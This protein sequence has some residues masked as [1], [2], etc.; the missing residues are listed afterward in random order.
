MDWKMPKFQKSDRVR[1]QKPAS[2]QHDRI[3]KVIGYDE[4]LRSY[5]V[6]L[7]GQFVIVADD[8]LTD[9]TFDWGCDQ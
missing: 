2:S 5:L 3:G 7:D 6:D 4:D 9:A 1:I 8:C